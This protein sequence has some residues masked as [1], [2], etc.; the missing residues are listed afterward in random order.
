VPEDAILG[1]QQKPVAGWPPR[2]WIGRHGQ[3]SI[4][5]SAVHDRVAPHQPPTGGVVAVAVVG[6]LREIAAVGDEQSE[7]DPEPDQ[8][9]GSDQRLAS[10]Q[11]PPVVQ[12]GSPRSV[13]T[14]PS[15]CIS[16][17]PGVD[18]L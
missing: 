16:N 4:A 12:T 6:R 1:S 9:T 11:S 15:V 14:R 18:R 7:A 8:E 2:G 13:A 10:R 5:S 17:P 3:E